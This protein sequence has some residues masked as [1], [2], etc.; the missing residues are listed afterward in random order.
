MELRAPEARR[1]T[2]A[3]YE[4]LIDQGLFQPDERLEL[5]NG[6]I[7][8]VTPQKSAHATA[9]RAIQEVL[10]VAFG[11]KADVR[12]QLPLA[13]TPDSAPEP[14]VAVVAGSFRDYRD[15]H[16]TNALLIVEVADASLRFDRKTK[17]PL[18][19]GA[20]IPEYWIVNL[21]DRIVEIYR[22]PI[23][24]ADG[25]HYRLV[26]RAAPGDSVTPLA[27]EMVIAVTD[28]LP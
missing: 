10:R 11:A 23:E 21:V 15:A 17:G 16:P 25:W 12:P 20:G 22:E 28:V 1:W 18:Y 4:R 19:A 5:V 3:E 6:E 26:H 14:D 8:A 2:R 7:L 9:V 24:T 13:L 27:T